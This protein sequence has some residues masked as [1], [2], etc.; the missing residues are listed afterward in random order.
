MFEIEDFSIMKRFKFIPT[1][2]L[3]KHYQRFSLEFAEMFNKDTISSLFLDDVMRL[4]I[5]NLAQNLLPTIYIGLIS[6]NDQ[7]FKDVFKE[8]YGKDYTGGE[9]LK[10]IIAEM[11]KLKGKLGAIASPVV[12]MEKKGSLK[13]EE[14][15]TYVEM[16]LE[17]SIDRNMKLYQFTY[18]YKLAVKRAEEFQKTLERNKK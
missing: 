5:I 17:R 8:R 14:V 4:K 7:Y 16:I 6:T 9:D 18:Q 3:V 12:E 15:I 13:F 11:E 1:F 2:L 10:M